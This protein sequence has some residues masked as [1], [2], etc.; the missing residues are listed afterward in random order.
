MTSLAA[1]IAQALEQRR[2]STRTATLTA[3][4]AIAVFTI[5]YVDWVDD[6]ATDLDT[7]MQR[8]L[9][10]LRQSVVATVASTASMK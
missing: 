2:V 1:A 8:A 7:L 10:D 5:A 6:P 9:A 3:Q 4:A